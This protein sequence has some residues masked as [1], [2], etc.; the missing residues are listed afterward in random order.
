MSLA[1]G[2]DQVRVVGG[3]QGATG[4][5][6]PAVV[7]AIAG[8]VEERLRLAEL[9]NG[10]ATVLLV[11]STA[12][13]LAFLRADHEA[14]GT[15]PPL[16]AV[17]EPHRPHWTGLDVDSDWRVARWQGREVGLSP[18]EH[19]LLACLLDHVGHILT[20]EE[21]QERVWGNDHLGG[22]SHVQSVVKRLRRKLDGLDSPVQIDSVRGVGLRLVEVADLRTLPVPRPRAL[23][24]DEQ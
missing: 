5:E 15:G 4:P 6:A 14:A 10:Q 9:V 20:F 22:R 13:A 16:D 3:S 2:E 19:D 1:R 7:I 24:H 17:Q 21:L 18:L 8:S 11:S 23:G 12:E